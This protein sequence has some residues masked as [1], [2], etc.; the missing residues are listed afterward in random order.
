MT[1][2]GKHYD[3]LLYSSVQADIKLTTL[4]PVIPT[5]R[6]SLTSMFTNCKTYLH[7][8]LRLLTCYQT[9]IVSGMKCQ[10][11]LYIYYNTQGNLMGKVQ[12]LHLIQQCIAI[13]T[14][15]KS[16][17]FSVS[18][19]LSRWDWDHNYLCISHVILKFKCTVPSLSQ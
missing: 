4:S 13:I 16:C 11:A 10:N 15:C 6:N 19:G 8:L 9:C 14:N 17:A 3:N 7:L 18:I 12:Q 2:W 5:W 1:Y